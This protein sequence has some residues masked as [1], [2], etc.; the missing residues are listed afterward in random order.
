MI[1]HG[2]PMVAVVVPM[3]VITHMHVK[4]CQNKETREPIIPPPKRVRD[5]RIK[6]CIIGRRGV[7]SNHGG[8]FAG[9][10]IVYKRGV[11]VLDTGR[12]ADVTTGGIH[13]YIQVILGYSALKRV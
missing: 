9:I 1:R 13:L 4:V 8:S 6:I 11:G 12:V 7:I 2:F 10:I 5:P 3:S